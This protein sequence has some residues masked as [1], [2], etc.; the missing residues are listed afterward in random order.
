VEDPG[1]QLTQVLAFKKSL[2]AANDLLYG[3]FETAGQ[4]EQ[5]VYDALIV[6]LADRANPTP[7]A[8]DGSQEAQVEYRLARAIAELPENDRLL[9]TLEYYEGLTTAEIGEALS[10]DEPEA[11]DEVADALQGLGEHLADAALAS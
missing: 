3:E 2:H 9:L 11:A 10:I 4:L 5:N 7:E 8:P 6:W 1:P